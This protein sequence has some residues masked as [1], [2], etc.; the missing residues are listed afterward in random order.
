MKPQNIKPSV[1]QSN[2][3][4]PEY[5]VGVITTQPLHSVETSVLTDAFK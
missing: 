5:E 2:T 4:P 1:R 3:E